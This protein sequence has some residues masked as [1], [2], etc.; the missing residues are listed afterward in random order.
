M[1][2][3][4][5]I[6]S[7]EASVKRG[8]VLVCL[9]DGLI[10]ASFGAVAIANGLPWWVPILLSSI[11][12]AG[13]AQ[14]AFVGVFMAGG[15]IWS[16]VLTALAL[17]LR[18]FVY[19]AGM[20]EIFTVSRAWKYLAPFALT[21]ES[22]AFIV[23]QKTLEMK[24]A[25]YAFF[26]WLMYFCWV[27]GTIVGVSAGALIGD[28]NAYGL[29]AAGPMVLLALVISYLKRKDF[30][31]VAITGAAIA[32]ILEKHLPGGVPVL[33]SLLPVLV[34]AWYRRITPTKEAA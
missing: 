7:L 12:F 2:I 29:D 6:L 22:V 32:V 16:A 3:Y 30:A 14:F 15:G 33:L 4:R 34:F 25:V 19:G 10:G 1:S 24:R 11:V 8:V 18:L 31:A 20:A 26:C 21:D 27:G 23:G 28:P 5:N 17:N 13:G 9:T